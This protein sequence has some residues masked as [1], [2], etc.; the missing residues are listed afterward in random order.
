MGEIKEK[1]KEYTGDW[2]NLFSDAKE[3]QKALR[4][5]VTYGMENDTGATAIMNAIAGKEC[6]WSH[7]ECRKF[8]ETLLNAKTR[9]IKNDI[10]MAAAGLAPGYEYIDGLLE[11]RIEYY[12]RH[13]INYRQE[14]KDHPEEVDL[15][16]AISESLRKQEDAMLK[17]IADDIVKDPK[18]DSF[19]INDA[20]IFIL[21]SKSNAIDVRFPVFSVEKYPAEFFVNRNDVLKKLREGFSDKAKRKMIVLSGMGGVGKTQIAIKYAHESKNDYDLIR[22]LDATDEQTLQESVDDLLMKYDTAF[23]GETDGLSSAVRLNR[24]INGLSGKHI[25]L[26]YDNADYLDEDKD[27]KALLKKTLASYMPDGDYHILITTRCKVPYNEVRPIK[28]DVFEPEAALEYLINKA[29]SPACPEA[30]ELAKRLGYLPLAL[31]YVG[32]YIE[33]Q[34]NMTYAEYLKQWDEYGLKLFDEEDYAETTI[35][36]A[37]TITL[38]KLDP[39]RKSLLYTMLRQATHMGGEYFAPR[40]YAELVCKTSSNSI[41]DDE[42]ITMYFKSLKNFVLDVLNPLKLNQVMNVL[43]KYS[44]AD[45]DGT[46]MTIHPMLK[47]TIWAELYGDEAPVDREWSKVNSY[48]H[49]MDM[50]R[51]VGDKKLE[52][53]YGQL[54]VLDNL[55]VLEK[56]IQEAQEEAKENGLKPDRKSV[57]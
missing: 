19:G 56:V 10:I 35:R 55:N 4:K 5:S 7:L 38:D 9:G 14:E 24:F 26:I 2:R 54:I 37:L 49:L 32:A 25:L 45:W 20:G 27:K 57:V 29:Q 52:R 1:R 50:Y 30:E 22:W 39:E 36:R 43:Q 17:R 53:K 28:V 34:R 40:A 42:P 23:R 18:K 41:L 12:R 44:L 51:I 8:L 13:K 15:Y 6:N 47:E 48:Y 11:R 33:A 21:P 31:C 46:R 16:K 3:L